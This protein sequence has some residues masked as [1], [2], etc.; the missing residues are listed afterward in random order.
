MIDPRKSKFKAKTKKY[1]RDSVFDIIDIEEAI[2]KNKVIQNCPEMD[3][4]Y[5]NK[6]SQK[7]LIDISFNDYDFELDN[8]GTQKFTDNFEVI[9]I[10]GEGSFGLVFSAID[11][12]QGKNEVA[13]KVLLTFNLDY[14]KEFL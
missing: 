10:L 6:L 9:E 8:G 2:I 3:F 7:K 13:I 12:K 11:L 5:S 14:P 1:V 4:I